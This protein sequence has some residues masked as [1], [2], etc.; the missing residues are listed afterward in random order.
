MNALELQPL[1]EREVIK[2]IIFWLPAGYIYMPRFTPSE[3][4]ENDLCAVTKTGFW[5]EFE[6][7][8]SRQDF[9]RD[10][11]K[12]VDKWQGWDKPRRVENKHD[13]M[14]TTDR[15][16][17]RFYY[18]VAEGVATIEDMPAWAGLLVVRQE[19]TRRW[20]EEV[21]K[22]PRRHERKDAD[23]IHG[24]FRAAWYRGISKLL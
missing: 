4:W 17:C 11:A 10:K 23:V 14:G 5:V 12:A 2:L 16:P 24:M 22:A 6:V 15:G 8:L 9:L 18:V 13:L 3:W 20:I 21:K 7:K 1:N 19:G